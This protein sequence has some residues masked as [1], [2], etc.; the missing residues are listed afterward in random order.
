MNWPVLKDNKWWVSLVISITLS[1]TAIILAAFENEYW[2]VT[3]IL[4]LFIASI[5]VKR[6]SKLT[7]EVKE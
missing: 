2:I 1:I 5:G 7:H 4:S 3:L 6:A